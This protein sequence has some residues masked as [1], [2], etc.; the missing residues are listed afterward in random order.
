MLSALGRTQPRPQPQEHVE[1]DTKERNRMDNAMTAEAA[2]VAPLPPPPAA[3]RRCSLLRPVRARNV[4]PCMCKSAKDCNEYILALQQETPA[5]DVW[6]GL[7]YRLAFDPENSALKIWLS[8]IAI[9]LHIEGF[10]HRL[11]DKLEKTTFSIA[12]H[13]YPRVLLES[14]QV[15]NKR[16][17]T[18]LLSPSEAAR[19][20]AVA[21]RKDDNGRSARKVRNILGRLDTVA[22][23]IERASTVLPPGLFKSFRVALHKEM[24]DYAEKMDHFVRSPVGLLSEV[25]AFVAASPASRNIP[26]SPLQYKKKQKL[27]QSV[28]S[29]SNST[30]DPKHQQH[31]PTVMPS[32]QR[33]MTREDESYCLDTNSRRLYPLLKYPPVPTLSPPNSRSL[34]PQ[35]KRHPP[36][37]LPSSTGAGAE[38]RLRMSPQSSPPRKR[39]REESRELPVP[40][41]ALSQDVHNTLQKPTQSS[42]ASAPETPEQEGVSP[43]LQQKSPERDVIDVDEDDAVPTVISPLTGGQESYHNQEPVMRTASEEPKAAPLTNRYEN[44]KEEGNGLQDEEEQDEEDDEE[45]E[46]AQGK[47]AQ[48][49]EEPPCMDSEDCVS[50]SICTVAAEWSPSSTAVSLLTTSAAR[51][52]RRTVREVEEQRTLRR[53]VGE[54]EEQRPPF[55]D[56]SLLTT[57]AARALRRTVRKAEEQRRSSADVSLLTTSAT[58]AL[59]RTVGE[60]EETRP[61]SPARALRRTVGEVEERR[62]PSPSMF[63]AAPVCH[64]YIRQK[65]ADANGDM[66]VVN[67]SKNFHDMIRYLRF[68]CQSKEPIELE[69]NGGEQNGDDTSFLFLCA[70]K[71]GAPN[72]EGYYHLELNDG[73]FP[74]Q[75]TTYYCETCLQAMAQTFNSKRTKRSSLKT[76]ETCLF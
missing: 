38:L 36:R 13:H 76:T 19:L 9:L 31:Q 35:R 49:K 46:E 68:F 52:V 41:K 54:V 30:T 11:H 2:A 23:I 16:H 71:D 12:R 10:E 62:P 69:Q 5:Y 73:S 43:P 20:Q 53:T 44:S 21:I 8:V 39:V 37:P 63:P 70:S 51:A 72:C 42:P 65:F 32:G 50:A 3:V 47:E 6:N 59:R 55:P 26:Q 29:S 33:R 34:I 15:G 75:M 22:S 61:S 48:D 4:H 58:R 60:E 67:Q 64:E 7:P 57:S 18:R 66:E 17:V 40:T 28:S 45:D 24:E 74:T 1:G 25:D 27:L 14:E 56:V